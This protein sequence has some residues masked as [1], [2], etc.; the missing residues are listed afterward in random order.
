MFLCLAPED[1]IAYTDHLLAGYGRE[2]TS[3][4]VVRNLKPLILAKRYERLLIR[5]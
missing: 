1:G 4:K 3:Q 2:E 5:L